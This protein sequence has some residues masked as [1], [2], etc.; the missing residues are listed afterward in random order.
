MLRLA[1]R[2]IAPPAAVDGLRRRAA[3]RAEAVARMPVQHGLGF[4]DRR[5]ML[6]LDQ[7]LHRDRAQVGHQKSV[8]RL[9]R[10]RRRRRNADAETAGAVEVAEEYRLGRGA[11]RARFLQS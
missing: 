5:Q 7:A 10:F 9:E 1:V 3:I 2:A 8:A 6:G 4:G 11:E